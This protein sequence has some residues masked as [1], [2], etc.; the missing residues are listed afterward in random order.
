M[1]DMTCQK[2]PEFTRA[3][4]DGKDCGSDNCKS[5][6]KVIKDGTCKKC[7]DFLVTSRSK[8]ECELPRCPNERMR[9]TEE[10]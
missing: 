3:Q 6:E 5:S 1:P 10:G 2:C 7:E 8:T 9:V 4:N